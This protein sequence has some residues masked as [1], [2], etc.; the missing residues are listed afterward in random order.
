M[1]DMRI[2]AGVEWGAHCCLLLDWLGPDAQV[3]SSRLAAAF[4]IPAP[5]LN[6]QLQLLVKAGILDSSRGASGGF[7]LRRS[8]DSVTML[9]VV[10]A[11]EGTQPAFRCSEIRRCGLGSGVPASAFATPC[12]IN[13]TMLAAE[14]QWRA[15]LASQTL[16]AV[17]RHAE[18]TSPGLGEL[19]RARFA[20]L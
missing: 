12:S 4:D 20:Q 3:S 8:L 13:S 11:I 16:R 18:T 17:Q 5:Y 1:S 15:T 9:D 2:G 7:S 6:K 14:Q 10:D 19:T